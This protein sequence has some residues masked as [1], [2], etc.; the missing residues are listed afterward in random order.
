M[1]VFAEHVDDGAAL[2]LDGNGDLCAREALAKRSGP[3]ST[4]S[5]VFFSLP[6]SM[7]PPV[8]GTDATTCSFAAQSIAAKAAK[9]GSAKEVG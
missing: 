1:L 7:R 3:N 4:A 6:I 5:G 2:L 9:L 8:A